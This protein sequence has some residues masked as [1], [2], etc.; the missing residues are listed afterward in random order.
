[1]PK[2]NFKIALII[3]VYNRPEHFRLCLDSVLKQRIMPEEVIIADDGSN[4][5]I[6]SIVEEYRPRFKCLLRYVF[7]EHL[8]FRLSAVRNLAIDASTSDYLI[9]IDQDMILDKYFIVDYLKAAAPG[10]YIQSFG[11]NIQIS[12][13]NKILKQRDLRLSIT[14]KGITNRFGVVRWPWA[15]WFLTDLIRKWPFKIPLFS[16]F[17]KSYEDSLKGVSGSKCGFWKQD[18]IKVNGFN[19]DIVGW[20]REDNE[21][22]QR[23]INSGVKRKN[24]RYGAVSY[25]LWH[26]KAERSN[27]SLNNECYHKTIDSGLIYC[28]NGLVKSRN[29]DFSLT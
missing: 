22:I 18:L 10:Y 6:K 9:F 27:F 21:L 5:D 19:E 8:G 20:G 4:E 15:F 14:S 25:H 29:K 2:N 13:R 1:M 7:Q 17:I 16:G 23:L 28:Q 3:T 11:R 12:L 26:E 24:L